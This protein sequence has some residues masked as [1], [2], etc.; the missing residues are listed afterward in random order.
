[1][2]T[3]KTG[4][5][6]NEQYMTA[7]ANS[8]RLGHARNACLARAADAFR[9]GDGAA[10]K[11]FSR[12]G[13]SLNEKMLNEAGEAAQL[14][15]KERR[16]DVQKA[17]RER[18]PNWSDDPSDRAERGKESAGGFGVIMGVASRRNIVGGDML[19]A[20]ERTE[21]LIDLH[22]LHGTEGSDIL[23]TFLAELEREHFRGLGE[24]TAM[25][26]H[27]KQREGKG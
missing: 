22:T 12:E 4:T 7:R 8:I 26:G 23:G 18:D 21:C 16:A 13:K 27:P 9:R 17:V 5:A 24:S 11:R 20:A 3:V 14:L 19:S 10:A 15:V 1:L 6:T 2:P 25:F